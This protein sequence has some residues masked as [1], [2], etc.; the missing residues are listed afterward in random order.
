M[1]P[2]AGLQLAAMPAFPLGRSR[3]IS[4]PR[5]QLHKNPLAPT[6]WPAFAPERGTKLPRQAIALAHAN[7]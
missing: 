3:R 6:D 4:L 2:L 1:R 5:A 7:R